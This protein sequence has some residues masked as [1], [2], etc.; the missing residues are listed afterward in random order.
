MSISY[1]SEVAHGGRDIAPWEPVTCLKLTEQLR[2]IS[3]GRSGVA[4]PYGTAVAS[5]SL[6]L[7]LRDAAVTIRFNAKWFAEAPLATLIETAL[8][9]AATSSAS[10][11]LYTAVHL[12]EIIGTYSLLPPRS[13][14]QSVRFLAQT[15]YHA[16][17]ANRLKQLTG[18]VWKT[19]RQIL[20]SH[21][22]SQ[23]VVALL[24]I[25]DCKDDAQ[26]ESRVGHAQIAGALMIISEKMLLREDVQRTLPTPGLTQLL[27]S[28][29]GAAL[30][31]T[32]NLR[33]FIMEIVSVILAD[34]HAIQDLD[35][36]SSWDVLL[37]T[38]ETCVTLV[39]GS[40]A[41]ESVVDGVIHQ[42]EHFEHRQY[43][44]LAH[45]LLEVNRPLMPHLSEALLAPWSEL[46]PDREWERNFEKLLKRL[47]AS[48]LYVDELKRLVEKSTE[49]HARSPERFSLANLASDFQDCIK[50][51]ETTKEA[52]TLLASALVKIFVH[53][54]AQKHFVSDRDRLFC[55]ICS[56]A[57]KCI[58]AARFILQIRANV[59][60]E[61]YLELEPP[62]DTDQLDDIS[63]KPTFFNISGVPLEYCD[64]AILTVIQGCEEWEIYNCFLTELTPSLGNHTLFHHRIGF[65]KRLREIVC[66]LLDTGDYSEP[67]EGTGLTKLY[68]TRRLIAILTSILGYHRHLSKQDTLSVVSIFLNIA[69]SRD[70]SISIPCVHALTICCYELPDLMSSYMDDIID[71]MSKMVTQRYLAIHVLLFLAGLSRLPDLFRNFQAHDYK[72]IFGVCGNYLQSIRGTTALL[73]R[74][75]T[76]SSDQSGRSGAES[77]DALPEY[78]YALAHHVIAFWY[79]AL[80]SDHRRELKDYIT[81][82]LRYPKAD[83]HEVIEDQGLV[84]IDMMDRVDAEEGKVEEDNE[85]DAV[86]G[87]LTVLHR[88]SGVLIITTETALKTCKTVA[89]IRRPTGIGKRVIMGGQD[90]VV[91]VDSAEDDY[92]CVFPND[93]NGRTCGRIHIPSAASPLGSPLITTLPE[94]DDA[95]TRAIQA[96]DRTSA[97][98]SHKAGVIYI[99]E[100]QTTED[101]ILQNIQG[102]PDYVEF[103]EG[104][105]DLMKLK[106]AAFN[107]QGL[108]RTD[109]ADGQH[110]IVWQNE[111]TELVF[112]ITTLMPNNED[113]N[114]NTAN[115]KRHIGNDYVNIVFNNSGL[116]FDFN[117]FPS[118][119][120]SVYIVITP[121]AR[122]SFLQTRRMKQ[123]DKKD[124]FYKVHVLIRPGYPSI[125]SAAEQKVVSAAS[126]PGYVRNLALND[127]VFSL[128]WSQRGGEA[129]EYPSSWRS[130]LDQIR[131][132]RERYG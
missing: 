34:E 102:S 26:L 91:S 92:I 58:T 8:D 63:R 57:S 117:T 41:A 112:H 88:I 89:T 42:I 32:D 65:I 127:C 46:L 64:E 61:T 23:C 84:T 48:S 101:E 55:F 44:A 7:V 104:L 2:A 43:E 52:T 24:E 39:P 70:Y 18:A 3:A 31:G 13:L 56:S 74:Q 53:F 85:F 5:P 107:T 40:K 47:S 123:A 113:V 25:V 108:D 59:E 4:P 115:K 20:E 11:D 22:G 30:N 29:W 111:V 86:D 114:L 87:R 132:F 78:V 121:S 50:R 110:T 69:G 125:S 93:I 67:P 90:I 79:L 66:N 124:R 14:F 98:D 95:V 9:A 1:G 68:V 106:D 77:A 128:M 71:K 6:D 15:Y 73:E 129:G 36:Q 118:Q 120:N 54:G 82:C 60:G 17:R 109:D 28:L 10:V 96:F 100:D 21:L 72:K 103:V 49:V 37:E 81:S 51:S 99:G 130:R 35:V 75:R 122:T 45:L 94:E 62:S 12:M 16:T 33:E 27:D 83:D 38:V 116:P 19:L 80:K 76:P 126:L 105:G 131:R 119:F 97:L